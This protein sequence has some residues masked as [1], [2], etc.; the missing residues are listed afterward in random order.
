MIKT[1]IL[2][3]D[4]DELITNTIAMALRE[5]P[6][7]SLD[8][9]NDSKE[10]YQLASK[11]DYDLIISDID[12]PSMHGD[13]LFLHLAMDPNDHSKKRPLP[14]LLMISGHLNT[15]ELRA[16][17]QFVGAI[18]YLQKPFDVETLAAKVKKILES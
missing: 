1:K 5:N 9:T 3:V 12:M 18:D 13:V 8:V 10:A 6:S 4:D 7:Y 2:V 16:T 17:T 15:G 14:K 11:Q